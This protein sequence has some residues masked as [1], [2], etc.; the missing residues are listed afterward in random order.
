MQKL[1]VGLQPISG[2]KVPGMS[3]G[4]ATAPKQAA[5]KKPA[6]KAKG[7]VKRKGGA[8][9]E[10]EPVAPPE[11]LQGEGA[12]L[13]QEASH[14]IGT[15]LKGALSIKKDLWP[16]FTICGGRRGA[17]GEGRGGSSGPVPN[18]TRLCV[19]QCQASPAASPKPERKNVRR[20]NSHCSKQIE[21]NNEVKFA[22]ARQCKYK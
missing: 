21:A 6:A 17:W 8:D 9:E 12:N 10:S 18:G 14:N 16:A 13:F 4:K 5:A 11:I 22:R 2:L 19:L 20:N 3:G 7:R 15:A 1:T